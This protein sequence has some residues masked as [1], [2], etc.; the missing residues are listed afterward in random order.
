[1]AYDPIIGQSIKTDDKLVAEKRS[2]KLRP[3][4]RFPP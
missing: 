1:V 3:K 2:M 4:Y